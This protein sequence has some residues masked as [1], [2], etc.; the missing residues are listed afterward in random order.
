MFFLLDL[1]LTLLSLQ[2]NISDFFFQNRQRI[3]HE[4]DAAAA[5]KTS[6]SNEQLSAAQSDQQVLPR[7]PSNV[8]PPPPFDALW[9]CLF[10][11]LG[12]LC[13]DLRPA[14]RKSAGQTL[15]ST[16]SAHGALL[17]PGTW[18][19]VLWQVGNF[20]LEFLCFKYC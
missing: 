17:Q 1:F 16:I 13:V 14:V 8:I 10:S 6:S 18:Q 20:L 12:E 19:N 9:M 3:K 2:W 7:S 5:A 15:F 4:L 11:A